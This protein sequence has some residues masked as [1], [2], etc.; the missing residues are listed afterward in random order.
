MLL[1]VERGKGRKS[2]PSRKRGIVTRC[3]RRSCSNCC[4]PGGGRAGGAACCCCEAGC[5]PPQ[6]GRAAVGPSALPR[7]PCRRPGRRDQEAR[8]TTYAAAQLRHAFARARC[9]YSC[10]SNAFGSRQTRHHGALHQRRQYDDPDRNQP[11]RPAG[12]IDP[13]QT[14]TRRLAGWPCAARGWRSQTSFIAMEPTGAEPMPG[15]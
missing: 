4:A 14:A 15:I 5:F 13:G 2:L 8:L 3:C 11:T 9:R 1:R 12:T 7:R 6:P 10:D